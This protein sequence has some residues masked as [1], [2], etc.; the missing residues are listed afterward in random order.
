MQLHGQS[1]AEDK[2]CFPNG[3]RSQMEFITEAPSP[4]KQTLQTLG[5]GARE[6]FCTHQ[7]LWRPP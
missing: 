5:E 1:E 7:K 6:E 4:L 2:G 3:T